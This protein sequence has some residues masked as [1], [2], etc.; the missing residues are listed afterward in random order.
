MRRLTERHADLEG[1]G[2]TI[3]EATSLRAVG[4]GHEAVKPIPPHRTSQR[5]LP[6][7]HHDQCLPRRHTVATVPT[8]PTV[9]EA[10][11]VDVGGCA[12]EGFEYN[13]CCLRVHLEVELRRTPAAIRGREGGRGWEG[14]RQTDRQIDRQTETDREENGEV[15]PSVCARVRGCVLPVS[16]RALAASHDHELA[17]FTREARIYQFSFG[18]RD[19]CGG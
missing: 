2:D 9:G 13:V 12:S 6:W 10:V 11:G 4:R 16:V 17:N 8:V 18:F 1:T 7:D 14:D 3:E 5:T 19:E 15:S